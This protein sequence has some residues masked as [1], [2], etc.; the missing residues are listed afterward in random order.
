MQ[1]ACPYTGWAFLA[2]C[3]LGVSEEKWCQVVTPMHHCAQYLLPCMKPESSTWIG[4]K[5]TEDLRS[6]PGSTKRRIDGLEL[7]VGS[8]IE[9]A[10]RY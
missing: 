6:T 10:L 3:G 2:D 8:S 9:T 1:K 4:T 5:C 7:E